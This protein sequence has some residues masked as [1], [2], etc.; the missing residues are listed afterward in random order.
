MSCA[1]AMR[2][3]FQSRPGEDARRVRAWLADPAEWINAPI[4]V[5]V[6]NLF[7]SLD[8]YGSSRD[9]ELVPLLVE[10]Y[11]FAVS[12]LPVS[13]RHAVCRALAN[14]ADIARATVAGLIPVMLI[15]PDRGVVQ[16]VTFDILR[17]SKIDPDGRLLAENVLLDVLEA[18]SAENGGAILAGLVLYSHLPLI[19]RLSELS[20]TASL[21]QTREACL[22]LQGSALHLVL[23][24]LFEWFVRAARLD[25][26][27]R[28]ERLSAI[29]AALM[30]GAGLYAEDAVISE[31]HANADPVTR[32]MRY[33]PVR[34]LSVPEYAREFLP[35][36]EQDVAPLIGDDARRLLLSA[37]GRLASRA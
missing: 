9:D 29:A 11:R 21:T 33:D 1:Y 10:L 3:R 31:I 15:E 36:L 28:S 18:D 22:C 24:F 25:D 16:S 13:V 8:L 6:E 35:L 14:P 17:F 30:P 23:S 37:W 20:E 2:S 4:T 12:R 34:R 32:T 5:F 19:A 26:E 7:Q 27:Q